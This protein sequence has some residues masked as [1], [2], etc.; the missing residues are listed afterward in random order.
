M[1]LVIFHVEFG[2]GMLDN[3]TEIE[4]ITPILTEEIILVLIFI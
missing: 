4:D 1:T 2:T 3:G